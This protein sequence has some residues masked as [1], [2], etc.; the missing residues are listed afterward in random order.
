[1]IDIP[2]AEDEENYDIKMKVSF[3]LYNPTLR[4][5]KELRDNP[6]DCQESKIIFYYPE[7][8]NKYEKHKQSGI[9]E[10]VIEFMRDF[11]TGQD[12]YDHNPVETISTNLFTVCIKEV[13]NNL[14]LWAIISHDNLFNEINVNEWKTVSNFTE[15]PSI[16]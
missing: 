15:Q 7:S 12:D 4:P 2:E 14:F 6:E 9:W 13:E 3:M 10:G 5:P 8:I 16:F 11:T 1:M